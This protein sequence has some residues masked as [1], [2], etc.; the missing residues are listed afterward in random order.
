VWFTLFFIVS[1]TFGIYF[2]YTKKYANKSW[3]LNIDKDF[4]PKITILVPVHNE[5]KLIESKLQNIKNVSYPKE[6]IELIVADDASTDATL[7]KVQ[8][9][10]KQHPELN[11][12]VVPLSPRGGKAKAL[13][14]ALVVSS[15][16]IIVVSDV[17]TFWPKTILS[18]ALPYLSE[19][20]VG[21]ITGWGINKNEK[22]SWVTRAESNYLNLMF[23]LRL[24]ESRIYSTIRFEGGFCAYKRNAF[25]QFDCDSGADDSGTALQ[26]VQNGFR[27]ILVPEAIFVTDFPSQLK[28]KIKIKIR[29]ASQLTALWVKC[30]KLLFDGRLILPK[31]IAVFEVFLSIFNPVLFLVLVGVTFAIVIVYPLLLMTLA[32]VLLLMGIIPKTRNYLVEG[33]LDHFILF[34]ALVL[35]LQKKKFTAWDKTRL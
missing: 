21:G 18:K 20:N 32:L 23:L 11:V 17:D 8:S 14:K 6:K 4:Q 33:V 13:N 3:R 19:P 28:D 7:T 15:N 34:Y 24:G 10:I 2:A 27:T 29:R 25:T 16:D 26:I 5:E 30:L 35:H 12:N 9:F 22:Q 31:R 1:G